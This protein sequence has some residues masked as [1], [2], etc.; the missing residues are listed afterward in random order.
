A[1]EEG[2][3]AELKGFGAKTQEK[4][5]EGM[6]FVEQS[7]ARVRL[8]QAQEVAEVLVQGLR[9]GRGIIRLETCGSLRR[10]KEIIRDIDLLASADDPGPIM[11]RFVSLPAVKQVV[12]H[13]ETKS[14]IVVET[15]AAGSR[16]VINADL[17]VVRDDQFPFALHYFT[18][19]KEHNIA[20]RARA[21]RYG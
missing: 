11:E 5:L 6:T 9:K 14:S 16:V 15:V 18:G 19:S 7:G 8:D 1:C 17:R 3:V 4:I 13:G 21:Q 20:V 12:V 10:R 2:R